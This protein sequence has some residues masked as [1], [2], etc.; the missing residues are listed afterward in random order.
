MFFNCSDAPSLSVFLSLKTHPSCNQEKGGHWEPGCGS[1]SIDG[2]MMQQ[3]SDLTWQTN[4]FLMKVKVKPSI[5]TYSCFLDPISA[6]DWARYQ[7]MGEVLTT[8]CQT[9]NIRCTK[10]QNVFRLVF[11]LSLPNLLKP[12]VKSRV[13]ILLEQH[14]QALLQ[15]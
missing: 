10:S 6:S 11:Q 3:T 13:K 1:L 9:S 2:N 8:Y 7:P 5:T 4:Y 14:R 15:L 12:D